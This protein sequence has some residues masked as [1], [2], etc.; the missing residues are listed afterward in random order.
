M[1]LPNIVH[2]NI[3]DDEIG[4]IGRKAVLLTGL[5]KKQQYRKAVGLP[6]QMIQ[7]GDLLDRAA[8]LCLP[9]E[10]T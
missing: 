8:F 6:I 9:F 10:H 2:N 5:D 3:R 7:F 1:Q 4:Q